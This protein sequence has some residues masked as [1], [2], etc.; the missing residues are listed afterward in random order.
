MAS[1]MTAVKL[2]DQMTA[3]LRNITN[4]VN[5]MLSSWESLDSATAGGSGYGRRCR[6][7]HAAA[8]GND[9]LDQLGNEQQEFNSKVERGSDALS[10]M[11]VRSPVWLRVILA[12]KVR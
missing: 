4:A 3:P 12:C 9:A 1:I 11:A 5:M 2:N 6:D 7:P 10:G 8:R